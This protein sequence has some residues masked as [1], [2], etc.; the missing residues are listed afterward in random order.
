MIHVLR[1]ER[2]D[3]VFIKCGCNIT[4][5]IINSQDSNQPDRQTDIDRLITNWMINYN[6]MYRYGSLTLF[7]NSY[8]ELLLNDSYGV[9]TI[10]SKK[11]SFETVQV[12]MDPH[13]SWDSQYLFIHTERY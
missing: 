10:S 4:I 12:E 11:V 9:Y 7:G 5:R 8:N 2:V 6:V 3:M 13:S 1:A